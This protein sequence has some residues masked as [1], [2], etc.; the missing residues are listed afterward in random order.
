MQRLLDIDVESMRRQMG[1]KGLTLSPSVGVDGRAVPAHILTYN[2]SKTLGMSAL[3]FMR[4]I[5]VCSTWKN[6]IPHL[7]WVVY[8]LVMMLIIGY[9]SFSDTEM[10]SGNAC[11]TE[12]VEGVAVP[13][14]FAMCRLE[15]LLRDT[16][17][18]FRFLIAFILAGFVASTIRIW[19]LRRQNYAAL[20]GNARNLS[21]S[22]A[23]FLPV[24]GERDLM[25]RRVLLNRW[26]ILAYELAVLKPKGIMDS[27]AGRCVLRDSGLLEDGE[28]EAMVPGDRHSTVFWWIQT[29]LVRLSRE[30][31]LEPVFVGR[32]A[33][34]IS[35]MRAQAN[36]LMS[37]LDRD[38]P[39]S[40]THL[41]GVLV[42]INMF[43]MSTWK[44]IEWALWFHSF[45]GN[46]V[47]YP[48][49]W[50]DIFALCAWNLSYK[51]LYDLPKQLHNPFGDRRL[52]VA[53]ELIGGGIRRLAQQIAQ[54]GDRLPPALAQAV[55]CKAA[56]SHAN[57][58]SDPKNDREMV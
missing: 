45:G 9:T 51:A 16:K 38:R 55:G 15:R 17:T 34:S 31:A 49:F 20:C 56:M 4:D 25:E 46:I 10:G 44:G 24:V 3:V 28:W 14:N 5:T 11:R 33:A 29:E 37:S 22:I 30:G 23:S 1:V 27:E 2:P 58:K 43:I 7:A 8:A 54:V 41:C 32:L 52:D 18:E 39:F 47:N 13:Q 12:E 6:W 48:H 50:V 53:H 19:A 36:D 40:Y 21:I 35:D 57:G 42:H 26:V